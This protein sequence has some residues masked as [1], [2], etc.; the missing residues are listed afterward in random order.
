MSAD[1]RPMLVADVGKTRCRVRVV[2]SDGTAREDSGSSGTDGLAVPGG[3]GQVA[4]RIVALA[5]SLEL[6][7]ARSLA[8]GVAGALTAPDAADAL[9]ADLASAFSAQ[10][11]VASDI[12]TAHLGA[13]GGAPGTVLV[14]GTGAVAMG[15]TADGV[16]SIVDG[17]GPEIGD[18]GSGSWIGRTGIV[19]ASR[20]ADGLAPA[21]ALTP[22]LE[23]LVGPCGGLQHW[24]ND[25]DGNPGGHLGAFAPAVLDAARAGDSVACRIATD[26]VALLTQTA[27]AAGT[28][29][30]AVLGGLTAHDWFLRTLLA[31]LITA[32]LTPR[33]PRGTALDGALLAL[34]SVGLP[35]ERHFHRA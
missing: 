18:L 12:V 17:R 9:A 11:V 27:V 30:V 14:A 2:D 10:A 25:H 5:G 34:T 31:S 16:T 8:A 35:H 32:G 1:P 3:A 29:V 19:A 22:A 6:A 20:A 21:T 7:D 4:R 13:L 15:I 23:H 33:T 26:A 24:L 28:Q